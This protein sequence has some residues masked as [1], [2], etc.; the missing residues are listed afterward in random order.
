MKRARATS[1]VSL[2]WAL[3]LL[4]H[5][6]T[7]FAVT[8]P[9]TTAELLVAA[10]GGA[11][12]STISGAVAAAS[13]GSVIRVRPG[14]YQETVIVDKSLTIV[15]FAGEQATILDGEDRRA[16]FQIVGP[17]ALRCENLEFRRGHADR[18]AAAL[19]A[20]GAV[21]EFLNCT[22]HD[23]V[24]RVAGGSVAISGATS[25][26]EFVGCHFQRNRTGGDGGAISASLG[27]ELTL[28][29]CT[30]FANQAT[31][32]GG[33][34]AMNSLAPVV[35]EQSLFIENQGLGAGALGTDGG[36]VSLDGNT[37]FRNVS[38]DGASVMVALAS[39]DQ[40]VA[41]LRTIFCGDLEGAGLACPVRADRGC[42]LFFDNFS[43]PLLVGEPNADELVGN[44]E[45]CDFRALDLTLRRNSP[46][47][48][49]HED[50]G[51]GLIGALD[52]GCLESMEA[53]SWSDPAA[54]VRRVR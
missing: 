40:D 38:L 9:T 34:V 28:R 52:V 5:A 15:G 7:G 13:A 16:L 39:A 41:I 32:T 19:L 48:G 31:G 49:L 43:G 50:G 44:P 36:P 3:L 18:G 21:A 17:A 27:A 10:D 25:W 35:V 29:G 33:A 51:C 22:F 46:A 26:A 45:F 37:F 42:N 20:D 6:S 1:I 8:S 2:A 24:A 11:P 4:T 12:F 30:F 54:P 47:A 23:N 14:L 53:A